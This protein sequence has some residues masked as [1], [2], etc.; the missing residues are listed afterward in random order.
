MQYQRIERRHHQVA[1]TPTH[2][3]AGECSFK[4]QHLF[5]IRGRSVSRQKNANDLMQNHS[6]PSIPMHL[7]R[8]HRKKDAEMT[9]SKPPPNMNPVQYCQSLWLKALECFPVYHESMF[10]GSFLGRLQGSIPHSTHVCWGG[11]MSAI[12]HEFAHYVTLHRSFQS[13]ST[14]SASTASPKQTQ[15]H[16]DRRPNRSNRN[17]MVTD[18]SFTNPMNNSPTN[19]NWSRP[20]KAVV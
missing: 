18:S 9:T 16:P 19:N 15:G 3:E 11:D 17:V 7:R 4:L 1:L 10:R 12:L 20:L 2:E 8:R 14:S 5:L 13:G 6:L